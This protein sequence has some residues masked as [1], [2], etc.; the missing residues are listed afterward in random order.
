MKTTTYEKAPFALSLSPFFSAAEE[1]EKASKRVAETIK[2]YRHNRHIDTLPSAWCPFC[3][4]VHSTIG[5]SSARSLL[6]VV[7][8]VVVEGMAAGWKETYVE[9]L[10]HQSIARWCSRPMT[11]E[12]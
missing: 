9:M 3:V 10:M 11:T 2:I 1:K 12:H 7:A 4:V 5:T 6:V 8:V